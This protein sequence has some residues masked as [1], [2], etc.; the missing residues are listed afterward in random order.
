M[1]RIFNLTQYELG[2]KITKEIELPSARDTDLTILLRAHVDKEGYWNIDDLEITFHF[3]VIGIAT[4][5]TI[6]VSPNSM[7]R[8]FELRLEEICQHL[9]Y[10]QK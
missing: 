10:I 5:F 8:D 3:V 4:K 2:D 1:H 9:E 7:S 6:N